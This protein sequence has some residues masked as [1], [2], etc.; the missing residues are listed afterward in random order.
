MVSY[1]ENYSPL[2]GKDYNLLAIAPS[3]FSVLGIN[4]KHYNLQMLNNYIKETT[5][6]KLIQKVFSKDQKSFEAVSSQTDLIEKFKKIFEKLVDD[7]NG[8]GVE[9]ISISIDDNDAPVKN[10]VHRH[11]VKNRVALAEASGV[12]RV[13]GVSGLPTFIVIDQKGNVA[14]GWE[15]YHPSMPRLWHNEIDRLLK[16]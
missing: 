5:L 15:G 9:I 13:Y 8:K 12:D 3:Y 4:N 7:Y 1:Q 2:K 14:G 10:F 16:S 6:L 11:N